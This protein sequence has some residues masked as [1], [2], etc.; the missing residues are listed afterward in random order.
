[1]NQNNPQFKKFFDQILEEEEKARERIE[2]ALSE[3]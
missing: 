3:K 2:N 1:M